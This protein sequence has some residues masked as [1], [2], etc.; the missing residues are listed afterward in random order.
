MTTPEDHPPDNLANSSQRVWWRL[1]GR[2][3]LALTT[4]A[5]L[6]ITG[7]VLIHVVLNQQSDDAHV[8][9][10]AGRQRMLSQKV[11]KAALAMQAAPDP[12]TRQRAASELHET[13]TAWQQAAYGLRYGDA[14]LDLSGQNSTT[15]EAMY[16]DLEEPFANMQEAAALLL[17]SEETSTR[18]AAVEQLLQHEGAFLEGMNAIVF[19]YAEEARARVDRLRTIELGLLAITLLVLLLEGLLIFRPTAARIRQALNDLGRANSRLRVVNDDLD[20][21]LEASQAKSSFLATMSHEIRTQLTGVVGS[22]DVLMESALDTRQRQLGAII[23]RSGTNLLDLTNDILDFSKIEAEHLELEHDPFNLHACIE[24]VVAMLAEQAHH[25][26]LVLVSDI[27]SEVPTLYQGDNMRVRQIL[28]NLLSNAIK[29]TKEGEVVLTATRAT[30]A[31]DMLH[32]NVRDT[33]MGIAPERQAHLFQ[34]YHQADASTARHYGGTGLGLSIA[35]HLATLMD[36]DIA[37]ASTVG[38]GSTFTLSLPIAPTNTPPFPAR[39]IAQ[40]GQRLLIVEV[41]AAT[42]RMLEKRATE[43]GMTPLSFAQAPVLTSMPP[44]DVALLDAALPNVDSLSLA[45]AMQTHHPH[46]PVV[47]LTSRGNH[48]EDPLLFA[49]LTKPINQDDLYTVLHQAVAQQSTSHN[50]PSNNARSRD[51]SVS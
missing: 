19:Q 4:V 24:G 11:T 39:R 8:I 27:A 38:E 2:Y 28:L 14:T 49:T 30:E 25:K 6:T 44:Y 50:A 26:G 18:T 9:N 48:I 20:Q 31:P 15:V 23:Q 46:A 29:F 1:T 40:Q 47:L 45:Q 17:A 51:R 22:I 13:L 21:A 3:I 5:L 41:H 37:V 12:T 32:I 36:G 35:K 42:R 7:Q 43:W 16:A 33:G 10:I 34:A